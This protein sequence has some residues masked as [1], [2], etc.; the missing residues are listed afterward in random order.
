MTTVL[1]FIFD[2]ISLHKVETIISFSKFESI[3]YLVFFVGYSFLTG[4]IYSQN[5]DFGISF[6]IMFIVVL[7]SFTNYVFFRNS[8][9]SKLR[10]KSRIHF[11]HTTL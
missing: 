10:I 7:L 3:V 9:Y 2:K 11:N 4:L 5:L 1:L 6:L 8:F